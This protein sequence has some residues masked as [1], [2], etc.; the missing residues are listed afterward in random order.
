MDNI[1][2]NKK[3][4]FETDCIVK[5]EKVLP[6]DVMAGRELANPRPVVLNL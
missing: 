3:E 5:V 4:L 6:G 1:L 2:Q